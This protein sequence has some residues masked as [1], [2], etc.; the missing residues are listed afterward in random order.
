MSTVETIRATDARDRYG[1]P[2]NR[3]HLWRH[4][5][6]ISPVGWQGT[7][8]LYDADQLRKLNH[9]ANFDPRAKR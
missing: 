4:R 9:A 7:W 3:I 6:K 2:L 8:P 1:I 5:G